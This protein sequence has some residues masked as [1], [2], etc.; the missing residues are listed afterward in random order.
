MSTIK[1]DTIKTV[2]G[3]TQYP[4]KAW[5]NFNGTAIWTIKTGGF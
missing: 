4:A 3:A 1:V 5:M 2:A